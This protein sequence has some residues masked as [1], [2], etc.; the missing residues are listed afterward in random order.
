MLSSESL[1]LA[2]NS[3]CLNSH[4]YSESA[5]KTKSKCSIAYTSAIR[6]LATLLIVVP[7]FVKIIF[8]QLADKAGEVAVLEVFRQDRLCELFIL[9]NDSVLRCM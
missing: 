9:G 2:L 3:G 4:A 5:S 6:R 7:H 1:L 8:V